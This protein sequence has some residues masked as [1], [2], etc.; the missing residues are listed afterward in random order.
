MPVR[1][2]R[3][4]GDHPPSPH[5]A[6]GSKATAPQLQPGGGSRP[7]AGRL[8]AREAGLERGPQRGPSWPAGLLAGAARSIWKASLTLT[9]R[10]LKAKATVST[11]GFFPPSK[12]NS[13][14]GCFILAH[15]RLLP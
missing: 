1:A 7:K 9:N 5:P 3:V 10:C 13:T 11:A 15:G 2:R 14:S 8:A 6:A 4:L 12:S